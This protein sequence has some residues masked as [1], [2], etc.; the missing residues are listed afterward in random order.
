M[1][2]NCPYKNDFWKNI[3]T[4]LHTIYQISFEENLVTYYKWH[5][6][7]FVEFSWLFCSVETDVW[8]SSNEFLSF[9]DA[10]E[11]FHLALV[12][13]LNS[14]NRKILLTWKVTGQSNFLVGCVSLRVL[15]IIDW[16]FGNNLEFTL[17]LY[18]SLFAFDLSFPWWHL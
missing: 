7:D 15:V 1:N 5:I 9:F 18:F 6:F 3:D 2:I 8:I 17:F 13:I 12:S 14:G 4:E 10:T 16:W 11:W